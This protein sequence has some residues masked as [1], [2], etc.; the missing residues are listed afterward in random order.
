M[1]RVVP[2]F[3]VKDLVKPFRLKVLTMLLAKGTITERLIRIMEGWRHSGF[4]V[5]SRGNDLS[6][7]SLSVQH[8]AVSY[9]DKEQRIAKRCGKQIF[10]L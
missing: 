2:R 3:N 10:G 6:Q 5:F 9:N 1:F 7:R 8:S 4:N